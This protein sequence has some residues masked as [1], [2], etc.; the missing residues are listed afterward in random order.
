MTTALDRICGPL[1]IHENADRLPDGR[2]LLFAGLRLAE[3]AIHAAMF[4]DVMIHDKRRRKMQLWTGAFVDR[5]ILVPLAN[6]SLAE[7]WV[8]N[9]REIQLRFAEARVAVRRATGRRVIS[10]LQYD[11]EG[12]FYLA[13]L[14]DVPESA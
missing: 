2:Q 1:R 13:S 12:L 3:G 8:M 5:K 11:T 10:R 9:N 7:E 4:V 6:D 14:I